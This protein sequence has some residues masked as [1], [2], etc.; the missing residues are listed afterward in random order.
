M[1]LIIAVLLVF[2]L[3]FGHVLSG[4]H[5]HQASAEPPHVHY[6]DFAP[7]P[8]PAYTIAASSTDGQPF[9]APYGWEEAANIVIKNSVRRRPV[10]SHSGEG[11]SP[12]VLLTS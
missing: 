12:A 2:L 11:S 3:L 8:T 5:H 10:Q 6:E 7:V 9:H 1:V 4:F